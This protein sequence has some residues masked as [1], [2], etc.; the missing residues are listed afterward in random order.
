VYQAQ[1]TI[2]VDGTHFL[3]PGRPTYA[4]RPGIED[5]LLNVRTV[6][7]TFEDTLG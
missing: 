1:T 3:I 5:L 4:A 6:H 2:S 7:A